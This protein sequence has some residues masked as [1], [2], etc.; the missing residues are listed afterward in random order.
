MENGIGYTL[1]TNNGA[2]RG[3]LSQALMPAGCLLDVTDVV[4]S[5]AATPTS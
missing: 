4:R 3:L 5:A 2:A 1:S